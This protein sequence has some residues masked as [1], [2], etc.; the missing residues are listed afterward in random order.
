MS[1][2]QKS[3]FHCSVCGKNSGDLTYGPKGIL[4]GRDGWQISCWSCRAA[5]LDKGPYLRALAAEV[6]ASGGSVLLDDPLRYLNAR[7][8]RAKAK[9][10]APLP[11]PAALARWHARLE[12]DA[13]GARRYLAARGIKLRTIRKYGLGYDGKAITIPVYRDGELANLRR[14][15][16]PGVGPGAAKYT[17]LAGRGSQLY[18]DVPEWADGDL[19][20][21]EGELDALIARQHGFSAVTTTCGATLPVPLAEELALTAKTV[22]VIY[23]GGADPRRTLQ[24]LKAAGVEARAVDLGMPRNGDC[25]DWFVSGRSADALAL[26][27][28]SERRRGRNR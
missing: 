18:P 21:C 10:G 25:S 7:A 5:G 17:G 8:G 2:P 12:K 4:G 9:E 22:V 6:G 23:D 16:W 14:R 27:I 15:W 3:T 26:L 13:G 11:S 28:A 24:R 1:A 19:I 20:L